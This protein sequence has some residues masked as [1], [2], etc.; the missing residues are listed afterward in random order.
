MGTHSPGVGEGAV[1]GPTS[2]AGDECPGQACLNRGLVSI[3]QY[4]MNKI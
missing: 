2:A 1:Q 3:R 4:I